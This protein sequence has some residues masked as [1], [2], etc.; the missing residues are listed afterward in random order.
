MLL[1]FQYLFAGSAS[2][3]VGK[4]FAWNFFK[5]VPHF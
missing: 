3:G 2:T 1:Y 4:D 5:A